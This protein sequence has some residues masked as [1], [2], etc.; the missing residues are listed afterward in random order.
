M[1]ERERCDQ[2]AYVKNDGLLLD[3]SKRR[4]VRG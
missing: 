3:V 2:M 1:C 4:P